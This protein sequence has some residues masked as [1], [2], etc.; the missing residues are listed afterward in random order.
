MRSKLVGI[1]DYSKR[2]IK[3]ATDCASTCDILPSLPRVGRRKRNADNE[4]ESVEEHYKR[5]LVKPFLE[6]MIQE[7]LRR[8][9]QKIGKLFL[10]SRLICS[11]IAKLGQEKIEE[12]AANLHET[13]YT[14]LVTDLAGLVAEISIWA[15]KWENTDIEFRPKTLLSSLKECNP[16][17]YPNLFTLMQI[18]CILPV[19]S[20]EC[21]RSFSTMKRLKTY[22]RSTM[23]QSRLSA[24]ALINIHFNFVIDPEKIVEIYMNQPTRRL[25]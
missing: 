15:K 6:H 18:L 13:Y 21:E 9:S 17:F 10:P 12:I 1:D 22:I 25:W 4:E 11:N 20:A 2:L 19:S 8:F 14:D 7:L 24:L 23:G 5:K 16:G 3:I